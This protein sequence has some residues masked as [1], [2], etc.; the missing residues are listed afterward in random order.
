MVSDDPAS[1]W[2]SSWQQQREDL[3]GL[4]IEAQCGSEMPK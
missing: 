4:A 2:S 3:G 1:W